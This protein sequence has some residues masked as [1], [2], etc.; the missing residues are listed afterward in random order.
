M[1]K[2]RDIPREILVAPETTYD[3]N[4][5]RDMGTYR[6]Q[7]V[8]G[9]AIDDGNIDLC[10]GRPMEETY[11][12]LA[13]ELLHAFEYEWKI[14]IPHDL[15]YKMQGP[16]GFFLRHNTCWI[17]WNVKKKP[18]R[19]KKRKQRARSSH[20]AKGREPRKA[21]QCSDPLPAKADHQEG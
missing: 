19:A 1:S 10:Q 7:K 14:D 20:V 18:R 13:H 15:I 16:L 2:K 11:E 12:T 17:D 4:W 21:S 9:E 8:L 5:R 6:G 3:L